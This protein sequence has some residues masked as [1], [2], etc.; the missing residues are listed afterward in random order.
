MF[1][2]LEIT[3]AK[4]AVIS[5]VCAVTVTFIGGGSIGNT[6]VDS[7]KTAR[8]LSR[9][10]WSQKA[11]VFF[12]K[13]ARTATAGMPTAVRMHPVCRNSRSAPLT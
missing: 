5:S 13:V 2:E 8:H 7:R 12:S 9:K 3:A 4:A 11:E 10:R 6:T 1:R